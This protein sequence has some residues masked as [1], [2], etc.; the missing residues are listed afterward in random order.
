VRIVWSDRALADLR[1]IAAYIREQSPGSA[2]RVRQQIRDATRRLAR[3]PLSGRVVP[4]LHAGGYREVIVRED[5]I[6]YRVTADD[7]RI[8]TVVHGKRDLPS[9]PPLG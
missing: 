7:V 9:L 1:E 3:F 6:I 5:R 8:V 2:R 4:E